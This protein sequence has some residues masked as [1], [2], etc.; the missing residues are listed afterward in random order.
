MSR[1]NPR[2]AATELLRKPKPQLWRRMR[3]AM[4]RVQLAALVAA[5]SHLHEIGN[6]KEKEL[7]HAR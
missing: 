3:Q 7:V 5:K 4:A 1:S 2:P 6:S